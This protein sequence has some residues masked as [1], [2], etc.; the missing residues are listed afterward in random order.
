M[1]EEHEELLKSYQDIDKSYA[2]KDAERIKQICELNQWK[3]QA[4]VQL[5]ILLNLQQ[6]SIQIEEYT[7]VRER[8]NQMQDQHAHC[9]QKEIEM[10]ARISQLESA[11]RELHDREARLKIMDEELIELHME[12]EMIKKRLEEVD[13]YYKKY[14]QVYGKLVDMLKSKGMS[15]LEAF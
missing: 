4:T 5:K 8:L 11:E 7:T 12:E 2:E 9:K 6:H 1:K 3:K 13:A 10:Q 14:S 15:P